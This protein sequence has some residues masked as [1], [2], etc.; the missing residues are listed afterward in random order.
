MDLY[1]RG[2][3]T[4]SYSEHIIRFYD[5]GASDKGYY[6]LARGASGIRGHYIN[7]GVW[8]VNSDEVVVMSIR[9]VHAAILAYAKEKGLVK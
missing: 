5:T 2:S 9:D 6:R 1:E 7:M 8:N 4:I 3:V